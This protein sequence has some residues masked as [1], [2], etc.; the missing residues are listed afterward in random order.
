[1]P[2]IFLWCRRYSRF[3]LPFIQICLDGC[4]LGRFDKRSQAA[5]LTKSPPDEASTVSA[6]VLFAFLIVQIIGLA[7]G[8]AYIEKWL[9]G[10][11]SAG[12]RSSNPYLI[13]PGNS[14]GLWG[15]TKR[16]K[17]SILGNLVAAGKK[18]IV[19]AVNKLDLDILQG[20]LLILLG[21]MDLE[22]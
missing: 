11:E 9:Y 10:T 3:S 6:V 18:D 4:H 20:Q 1:M 5:S 15:F 7:L 13:A 14:V 22:R 16:Y 2:R 21:P 17:P 19:T 8:V 12:P